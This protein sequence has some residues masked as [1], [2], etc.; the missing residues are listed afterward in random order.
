VKRILTVVL[1]VLVFLAQASLSHGAGFLI[2]EHGAAAMAMGGAF[3]ALANNPSA[4]WHNPA[5]IAFLQGTQFSLGTTL[6]WPEA[7]VDLMNWPFP[8]QRRWDQANQTFYPSNV[9]ITQSVGDRVTVGFGFFSPYGLG[10]KWSEEIPLRY[11]GYEDDMK[12][13]FFNPAIAFKLTDQVSLGVGV[14]YIHSTVKFK[15]VDLAEFGP[16]G[17]YDVPAALQGDGNSF[18]VNAGLLYRGKNLSLGF[19]YRSGFDIDYDGSLALD[20]SGVPSALRPLVPTEANGT[21]TFRFPHVLGAGLAVN[22][23]KAFLLTADFHYVIWSRFDEFIVEFDNPA[24]E[25]LEVSENWKDSYIIRGGLQYMITPQFALRA[26]ILYDETPQ[27]V[28]SMD[29]LLPDANRVALTAGVGYTFGKIVLDVAYQYETFSDRTAPN[30]DIY[31]MGPVNLG[32]GL[33]KSKAQLLGISL[34]FVF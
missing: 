9:Y 18:S 33:Y 28:E 25:N 24:L 22:V 6:I 16:Y 11:L 17:S 4:I 21:T 3:V 15:L 34:S 1:F 27:P 14:S 31:L 23:T 5:G 13:Y 2:Y 10:S 29:P 19:N 30:R 20:T 8:S 32:E 7:S 26:G 12:T